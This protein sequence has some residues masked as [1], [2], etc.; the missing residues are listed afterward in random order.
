MARY[1]YIGLE[2]AIYLDRE[3]LVLANRKLVF[4]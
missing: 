2:Y 3:T 4:L 1:T